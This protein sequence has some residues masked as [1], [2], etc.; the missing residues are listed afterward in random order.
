MPKPVTKDNVGLF[1]EFYFHIGYCVKV[2]AV[3]EEHLFEICCLCLGEKRAAAAII[4]GRTPTLDARISLLS[5]LLES[6]LP[7]KG[8]EHKHPIL[9]E[10][11]AFSKSAKSLLPVRNAIVHAPS[12]MK[13]TSPSLA[14]AWV[15]VYEA[16]HDKMRGRKTAKFPLK[17]KDLH[18]HEADVFI[19]AT[20][21][22][23]IQKALREALLP[24]PL[25]KSPHGRNARR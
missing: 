19:L 20:A 6:A 3:V 9:V 2:W 8:N 1:G 4:Y 17:V 16:A 7:R 11:D 23:S 5:E 21:S 14:D 25:K 24:E 15:E 22:S 10:W 18:D 12:A 13:L